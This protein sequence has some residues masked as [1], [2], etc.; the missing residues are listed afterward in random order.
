[1]WPAVTPNRPPKRSPAGRGNTEQMSPQPLNRSQQHVSA[2]RKYNP[3]KEFQLPAS[4]AVT[5]MPAEKRRQSRGEV[6]GPN[7]LAP[8][9]QCVQA[10]VPFPR[11]S[12]NRYVSR[13]VSRAMASTSALTESTLF[14]KSARSAS[15]NSSSIIRST[16]P[17]PRMTGT[18]T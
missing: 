16:P 10:R 2:G 12:G 5:A 8:S 17:A 14:W 4:T 3:N 18:P 9:S 7:A 15:V 11:V 6:E 13:S 1:V